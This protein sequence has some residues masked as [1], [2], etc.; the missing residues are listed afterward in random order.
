MPNIHL[1]K[2]KVL[3]TIII[4]VVLI[5]ASFWYYSQIP[6]W[7]SCTPEVS[8]NVSSIVLAMI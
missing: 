8:I 7:N 6:K 3:A 4:I 1:D 5:T 2:K